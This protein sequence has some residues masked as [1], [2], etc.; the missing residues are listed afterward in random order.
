M[1]RPHFLSSGQTRKAILRANAL[2]IG[3]A[4]VAG[5]IFDFAGVYLGSGPQGRV[6]SQAPHAGIGFV[7]AH[8]LALILSGLLWRAVP[9]RSWHLTGVTLEVLLGSANLL[10]W[11]IFVVGDA[12]ALGYVTTSLH[13]SFAGL[14]LLAAAAPSL[15]VE[16]PVAS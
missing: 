6:L 9:A 4:A 7:E 5:L 15:P 10:F 14:H 13:W 3:C 8:G 12:L 16:V 1:P 2:Y 11:D